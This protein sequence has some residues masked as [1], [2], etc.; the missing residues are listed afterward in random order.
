MNKRLFLFIVF[1]LGVTVSFSCYAAKKVKQSEMFKYDIEYIKT[2]GDGVSSVKVWSYGKNRKDVM[3][4]CTRD[5]V[6]GVLFKGYTGQGSYQSPLV[7]GASG[8]AD[9][10]QF[11]DEFFRKGDYSR[12]ASSILDGSQNVVKIQGGC[13]VSAIVSVNVRL[14]RQHLEEAGIIRGLSTGF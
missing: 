4:R 8:Y 2:A 13:K 11:F 5:A 12:Y 9:N 10:Q 3:E 6:H 1:L 14:L 7:R